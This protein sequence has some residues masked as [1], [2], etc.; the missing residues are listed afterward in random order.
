MI[1]AAHCC[2]KIKDGV[3]VVAG[4]HILSTEDG[5]E[6]IRSIEKF[7]KH[8]GYEKPKFFDDICMLHFETAFVQ[9]KFVQFIRLASKTPY[10]GSLC[11]I[12]GWGASQVNSTV[13]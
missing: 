13:Q 6:Q 10:Y 4:E 3:Q 11:Q 5:T 12:S 7:I 8:S 9:T 2:D 1:T